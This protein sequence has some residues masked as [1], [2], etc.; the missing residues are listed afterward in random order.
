MMTRATKKTRALR[1]QMMKTT[2]VLTYVIIMM[3][4][5]KLLILRIQEVKNRHFIKRMVAVA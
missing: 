2:I 5:M 1:L 3:T 4:A